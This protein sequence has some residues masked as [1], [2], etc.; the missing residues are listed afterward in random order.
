MKTKRGASTIVT[1]LPASIGSNRA[2]SE[3]QRFSQ[4]L[5]HLTLP[6][7]P[8]T[9]LSHPEYST[10]PPTSTICSCILWQIEIHTDALLF[11]RPFPVVALTGKFASGSPAPERCT[12]SSLIESLRSLTRTFALF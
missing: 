12:V 4:N 11:A 5:V 2:R 1:S 10:I 8:R 6:S 7:L 9:L 3:F